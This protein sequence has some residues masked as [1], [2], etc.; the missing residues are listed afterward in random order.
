M[1]E[2]GTPAAQADRLEA[3]PQ[4]MFPEF[5]SQEARQLQIAKMLRDPLQHGGLA[6]AGGTGQEQVLESGESLRFGWLTA[7]HGPRPEVLDSPV[8][9]LSS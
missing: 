6:A 1:G 3:D 9:P 4:P 7:H 8:S 2:D 5:Q